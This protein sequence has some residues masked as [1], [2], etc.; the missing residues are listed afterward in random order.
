MAFAD[1]Y[2]PLALIPQTNVDNRCF[3]RLCFGMQDLQFQMC[4][5]VPGGQNSGCK[6]LCESEQ[7]VSDPSCNPH[8]GDTLL[9]PRDD[10]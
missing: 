2:V 9:V 8:R 4:Q 7:L 5:D 10:P 6:L 3:V 1:L